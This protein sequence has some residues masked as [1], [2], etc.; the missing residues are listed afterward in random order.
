MVHTP[1]SQ[2]MQ[3]SSKFYLRKL[4]FFRKPMKWGLIGPEFSSGFF[5]I[6]LK[7]SITTRLLDAVE[8]VTMAK[9]NQTDNVIKD[10]L[11]KT[12]NSTGMSTVRLKI[13]FGKN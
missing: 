10:Q 9:L 5:I 4:Y 13:L 6:L 2:Q 1:K 3:W 12:L 7:F 8:R 11:Q